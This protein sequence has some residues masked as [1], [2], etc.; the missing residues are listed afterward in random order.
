MFCDQAL[1]EGLQCPPY[2]GNEFQ[3]LRSAKLWLALPTSDQGC[4]ITWTI[5]PSRRCFAMVW[6]LPSGIWMVAMEAHLGWTP[7]GELCQSTMPD[8]FEVMQRKPVP[9]MALKC[10][11]HLWKPPIWT[12]LITCK[13]LNLTTLVARLWF[14]RQPARALTRLI[15]TYVRPAANRVNRELLAASK[16]KVRPRW[17]TVTIPW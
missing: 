1:L 17:C 13:S 6:C 15:T 7:V 12:F 3:Q 14:R 8:R 5:A 9:L 2:I 10:S 4:L 16:F 11:T